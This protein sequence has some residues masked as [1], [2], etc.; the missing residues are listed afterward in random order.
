MRP[1]IQPHRDLLAIIRIAHPTVADSLHEGFPLAVVLGVGH[2]EHFDGGGEVVAGLRGHDEVAAAHDAQFEREAHGGFFVLVL[3]GEE[4]AEEAFEERVCG[5]GAGG[6]VDEVDD[7]PPGSLDDGEVGFAVFGRDGDLEFHVSDAHVLD[8]G[9][10][11]LG[12]VFFFL[13]S[14]EGRRM[15]G[16]L[17]RD[18]NARRWVSGSLLTV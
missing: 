10:K 17:H 3:A 9:Y 8:L 14:D 5:G 1:Y 12:D 4:G 16:R 2:R 11:M 6:V 7:V 13:W 18:G 15:D